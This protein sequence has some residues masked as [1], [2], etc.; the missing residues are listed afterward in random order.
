MAP[1][2]MTLLKL[3]VCIFALV[4]TR[5]MSER[6]TRGWKAM[7]VEET[8]GYA[9]CNPI[10]EGM[11]NVH[12]VPH[13]HDDLGWLI[14]A[15]QYYYRQVQYIIDSV[16]QELAGDPSKRFN[17]VEVG[18]FARW[19]REQDEEK[20]DLARGLINQGRLEF[21]Q[22]GWVTNDEA[23][24]HYNADID[25]QTYGFEFMRN[26]VGPCGRARAGWQ[27]DPFGHSREQY[28]FD[29]LFF[30]RLDYQDKAKRV[31]TKTME[32]VWRGSPNNLRQKADIFTGALYNDYGPPAGFCFDI[33]CSDP[34][35]VDDPRLHDVNVN[36]R[37]DAFLA[38]VQDQAKAYAT[39]HLIMPMGSDY[40]YQAAHNWYKNLDKLIK[41]VNLRQE[42]NGS[43]V[44]LLYST[45][46]C[47]AYQLYLTNRTWSTKEDD[48]F[49]YAHRAHT[50][51]T[52]Y[53]TSRPTL[54][55]YIRNANTF[56]QVT[57]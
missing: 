10:K 50:F 46:S 56:L 33:F 45:P 40:Q 13:S 2:Q 11:V 19:F 41:Y 18:M 47:Y 8:C 4:T 14:T 37:V 55:F 52:G 38:A 23:V 30:G 36:E 29:A 20:R 31:K 32:F 27:I 34:E 25:H 7:P 22:S 54:K 17:F 1:L 15:D 44:N 5:T 53:F 51:W 35:I 48:F 3:C 21:S 6:K 49:P 9:S 42:T 24:T 57:E 39:S 16:V 26:N 43:C 12:L 28:G